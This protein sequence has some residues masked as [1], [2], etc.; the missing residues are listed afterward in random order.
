MVLEYYLR[1]AVLEEVA[2]VRFDCSGTY[3]WH[4]SQV[5][6]YRLNVGEKPHH[7]C[8]QAEQL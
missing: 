8:C 7:V 3:L 4:I 6:D 5:S 2:V 1:I